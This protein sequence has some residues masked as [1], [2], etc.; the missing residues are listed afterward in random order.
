MG[1]VRKSD[2]VDDLTNAIRRALRGESVATTDWA[3]ALDA[4][5][6]IADAQLSPREREVLELYASG[7]TAQSIACCRD[8]TGMHVEPNTRTLSEHGASRN[9]RIGRATTSTR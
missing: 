3:A 5:S 2:G 4:D 9:C 6:G 7:E 1:V 8:G